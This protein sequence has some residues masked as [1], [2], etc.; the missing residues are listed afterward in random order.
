MTMKY[1]VQALTFVAMF[2]ALLA[3]GAAA[4]S[5]TIVTGPERG[6]YVEFGRDLAKHVAEPLG[7]DLR[8]ST[9]KGSAENLHRLRNEKGVRLALVQSDVY[10]AFLDSARSGSKEAHQVIDPLRVIIPLYDEEVHVVVRADS[11]LNFIHEIKGR[12]INFGPLGSG[13][14]LTA[15]TLYRLMFGTAPAEAAISYL[16][17]EEALL[18]LSGNE[19]IDA[20]IVVSGQPSRVFAQMKPEARQ[21]IK[22]L[23]LDPNAPE[24]AQAMQV[25][26]AT[27]IRSSSYRNLLDQDVPTLATKTLLVTYDYDIASASGVMLGRLAQS[28]CARMPTLRSQGHAKWN[29]VKFNLPPLGEGWR[30]HAG[31]YRTLSRCTE[32]QM[33]ADSLAAPTSQSDCRQ[34]DRLLGL[35]RNVNDATNPRQEKPGLLGNGSLANR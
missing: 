1:S 12:R 9:S 23:R 31:S 20:A 13:T 10:S 21:F 19:G 22:L 34:Q 25:Y 16:P 11:P 35:C 6:V 30:Y 2:A 29:E 15:T 4:Q 24:S 7:I 28:L 3:G 5:H 8:V 14:P 26:Q 18:K 17:H 33:Q 32:A 27:A